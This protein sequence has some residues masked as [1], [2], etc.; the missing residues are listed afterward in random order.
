ML[1]L[2]SNIMLA[3]RSL[4]FT[5]SS[6]GIVLLCTLP[7]NITHVCPLSQHFPSLLQVQA[8]KLT[9]LNLPLL[10][11]S[12]S[13]LFCFVFLFF[14]SSTISFDA[15]KC[16]LKELTS[17]STLSAWGQR[18]LACACPGAGYIDHLIHWRVHSSIVPV[19]AP[20][21]S[22]HP[23]SILSMQLLNCF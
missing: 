8:A 13:C 4:C 2:A 14:F 12:R 15:F 3:C 11:A 22:R 5:L 21:Y 17:K 6:C 19:E 18:S 9:P 23:T 1:M 10:Q 7:N 20:G 16:N